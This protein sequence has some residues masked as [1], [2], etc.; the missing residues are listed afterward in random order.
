[1]PIRKN[2]P[3]TEA[4][5]GVPDRLP[6]GAQQYKRG[7]GRKQDES[8]GGDGP[9]SSKPTDRAQD[10]RNNG[11]DRRQMT[12]PSVVPTPATARPGSRAAPSE[13]G[14]MSSRQID[15]IA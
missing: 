1:M 7:R 8:K 12:I 9:P 3:A 14:G 2:A 5:R 6:A 4:D 10:G 15:T 11:D 13:R